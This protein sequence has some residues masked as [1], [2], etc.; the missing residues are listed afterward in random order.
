MDPGAWS[1]GRGAAPTPAG[2]SPG[3]GYADRAVPWLLPGSGRFLTW[4][5]GSGTSTCHTCT[6]LDTPVVLADPWVGGVTSIQ[7]AGRYGRVLLAMSV[8]IRL[9]CGWPGSTW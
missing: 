5:S 6:G 7:P 4:V 8:A 9:G 2:P 3:L 1:P